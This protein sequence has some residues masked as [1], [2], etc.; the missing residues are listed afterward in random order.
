V[1]DKLIHMDTQDEVNMRL[2][3]LRERG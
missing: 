2:L 1:G 3:Q